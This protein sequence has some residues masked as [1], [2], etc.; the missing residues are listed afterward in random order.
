M[1]DRSQHIRYFLFSQYLA[2]GVRITLE[3]ILPV[4]IFAQFGKM[5]LGFSI[6]LG[7]LC[8]SISDAPG[9]VEHKRNGM[10]YCNLFVFVMALLTGFVNGNTALMG[11]LI[12][13][14]T[15]FFTMFSVYGARA[16]SVGTAD[17]W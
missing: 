11:L 15:F 14:S 9:P 3:I 2:D 7:A 16:A 4:I 8:A 17:Y 5:N 13:G 6:A 1:K 10:L 12:L